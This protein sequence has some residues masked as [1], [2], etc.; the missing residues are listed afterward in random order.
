MQK[1]FR[2]ALLQHT[3]TSL[4]LRVESL[5]IHLILQTLC[6]SSLN[7]NLWTNISLICTWTMLWPIL[8]SSSSAYERAR[9]PYKPNVVCVIQKT[10]WILLALNWALVPDWFFSNKLDRVG[11]GYKYSLWCITSELH[12]SIDHA[13]EFK[14]RYL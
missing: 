14:S 13:Y 7:V 2:T 4:F 9:N 12:F 1:I 8:Q 10:N 5:N 6:R 3:C 11:N